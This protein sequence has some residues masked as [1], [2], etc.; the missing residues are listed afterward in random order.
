MRLLTIT[1][2]PRWSAIPRQVCNC[3]FHVTLLK[4]QPA[5]IIH[6]RGRRNKTIMAQVQNTVVNACET[7]GNVC[8]KVSNTEGRK[9]TSEET[10]RILYSLNRTT[11][12]NE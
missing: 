9:C 3:Q 5:K 1:E 4:V 6:A 12:Q 2:P 8:K 10:G 7:C 11:Q